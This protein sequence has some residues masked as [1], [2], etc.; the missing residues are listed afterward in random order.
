MS[1]PPTVDDS[2][3]VTSAR[4]NGT[5]VRATG[6]VTDEA[7]SPGPAGV[8]STYFVPSSVATSIEAVVRL[9]RWTLLGSVKSTRITA[10]SRWTPVTV[11][12]GIPATRTS[13]PL[14]RPAAWAKS[15]E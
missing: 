14:D 12:S 15:A 2:P 4:S 5:V 7:S 9:P 10:W 8:S 1:R 3:L 11:P 13:S 6:M